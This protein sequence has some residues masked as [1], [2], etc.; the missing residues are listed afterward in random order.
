MTEP[1]VSRGVAAEK[2]GHRHVSSP[3]ADETSSFPTHGDNRFPCN[4]FEIP[5]FTCP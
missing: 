4:A 1:I 2:S 5:S 3:D